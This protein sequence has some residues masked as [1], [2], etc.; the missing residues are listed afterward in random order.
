MLSIS[1]TQIPISIGGHTS[2]I[3]DFNLIWRIVES[4]ALQAIPGN[5]S[6]YEP[7]PEFGINA[8]ATGQWYC[9]AFKSVF[10]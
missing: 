6:Q 1:T 8:N 7:H 4:Q 2:W 9:P 3:I 5:A 10:K